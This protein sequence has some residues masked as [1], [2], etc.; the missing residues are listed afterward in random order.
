MF[1]PQGQ[2]LTRMLNL[3]NT[4]WGRTLNAHSQWDGHSKHSLLNAISRDG[5]VLL[6]HKDLYLIVGRNLPTN[7]RA[8]LCHLLRNISRLLSRPQILQRFQRSQ[9]AWK[10]PEHL[11]VLGL[12]VRGFA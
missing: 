4:L 2:P 6:D 9:M 12:C 11:G 10:N 3:F 7:F 1:Y 8:D 5:D